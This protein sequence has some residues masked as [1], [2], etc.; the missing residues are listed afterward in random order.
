MHH[1][2]ARVMQRMELEQAVGADVPFA[3]QRCD[4]SGVSARVDVRTNESAR[5]LGGREHCARLGQRLNQSADICGGR[6]R[7]EANI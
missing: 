4:G 2:E 7:L 3:V 1:Q 5:V 6:G